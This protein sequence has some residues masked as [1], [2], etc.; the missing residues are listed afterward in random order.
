MANIGAKLDHVVLTVAGEA[1]QNLH[2]MQII[3]RAEPIKKEAQV[4]Q[5]CC[6]Y[7][8]RLA[9]GAGALLVTDVLLAVRETYVSEDPALNPMLRLGSVFLGLGAVSGAGALYFYQRN[10]KCQQELARLRHQLS[11]SEDESLPT[12]PLR[13]PSFPFDHTVVTAR[14]LSSN[15]RQQPEV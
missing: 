6:S 3:N 1:S 11:L 13:S 2:Q 4:F 12:S 7:L 10:E 14:R 9:L 8:S 5:R 15:G